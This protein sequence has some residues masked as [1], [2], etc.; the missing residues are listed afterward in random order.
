VPSSLA[1][2]LLLRWRDSKAKMAQQPGMTRKAI[3]PELKPEPERIRSG[4]E[5]DGDWRKTI[6]EEDL[7]A[8]LN[9]K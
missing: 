1:S 8:A 3:I 4:N 5:K 9:A 7:K 6:S 2:G